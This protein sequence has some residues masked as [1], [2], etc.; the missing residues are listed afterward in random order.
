MYGG[1]NIFITVTSSNVAYNSA[2]GRFTFDVTLKNLLEQKIGTTDGTTLDPNGVRVFFSSGPTVT[3]GSGV[4]AVV[5]DGFGTFTGGGQAFYQYNEV[6]A[7]NATSAAKQW[8]FIISPTVD[9]FDF[10]VLISA[11]VQFP[12][13]YIEINGQLPGAN[14]GNLHPGTTLPLTGVIK[15]ALG[16]VQPGVITWGTTDANQASVDGSGNVTGVRY[17]TPSITATSGGRNGSVLF[18]VT[19]TVR[20]WT[21]AVSTTWN[22]GGNWAGGYTPALVDTA[23]IPNGPAN[24]PAL[25]ASESIGALTVDDGAITH[26]GAFDMTLSQ[27]ATTGQTSGGVDGS[28]GRLLLTGTSTLGGRFSLVEISGNY[29]QNGNISVIAPITTAGGSIFSPG[30]L[31]FIASQ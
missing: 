4:L 13:G 25:T 10:L 9:T 23:H 8:M 3:A 16:V 18:N 1:Q 11:P 5:P 30:F 20:L 17:G 7:M 27:F 12:N 31:T 21:G 29:T 24:M 22:V 28:T 19:G 6:L 2:T 15:N 14:L 26:L